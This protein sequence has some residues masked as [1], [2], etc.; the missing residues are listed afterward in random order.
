MDRPVWR[1]RREEFTE[2]ER[3]ELREALPYRF[4]LDRREFLEV[5]GAG[6]L[7]S[8][9][10][11]RVSLAQSSRG[12]GGSSIEQRL[13]IGEDGVITVM[14]SKVEVGQGSRTQISMAAAEELRV[15]VG[16][17]RLVMADTSLVPDDGGTAGSRTTPST[18][19]RVRRGCAAA[20]ELLV[21]T[22]SKLWAIDRTSLRVVD[23][24]ISGPSPR[25]V[26]S[27]GDLARAPQDALKRDVGDGVS[28]TEVSKW[29]VLGTSVPKVSS[30]DI[31]TGAH[32][33][34]SDI[35]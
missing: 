16:S 7:I 1:E 6:I 23:G 2:P 10:A 20:R 32:R 34:A 30:V 5:L 4:D 24:K 29:K 13:H 11:A 3:Y 15:P 22:A 9:V 26:F 12:R 19:P 18:V 33:Y 17:V 35:V 14:T 25:Q 27:Y 21:D 31:V 8:T 28:V